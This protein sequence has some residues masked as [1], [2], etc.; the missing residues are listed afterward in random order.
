MIQ[1]EKPFGCSVCLKSFS[2]QGDLAAHKRIHT[3][4]FIKECFKLYIY[5]IYFLIK[6]N[7][8]IVA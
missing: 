7:V 8:R 3:G 1:G 4:T 5:K 2:Q 6:A